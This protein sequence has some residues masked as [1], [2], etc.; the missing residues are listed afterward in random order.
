MTEP[1]PSAPTPTPFDYSLWTELLTA[2]VTPEGKVDYE[3]LARHRPLLAAFVAQLGMASP[4]ATPARF[5]T[6]EHA[7]AYWINA[8]NAFVL[9][10]VMEEYPIRSVWKVQDGQFFV[11]TRHL[12][13]GCCCV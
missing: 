12:T 6:P 9:T 3:I 1:T 8:Y 4:D 10:A 2:I 5:P 13:G 7:L 11:R